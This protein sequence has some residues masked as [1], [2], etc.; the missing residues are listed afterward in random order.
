[1]I[2]ERDPSLRSWGFNFTTLFTISPNVDNLLTNPYEVVK[3][4]VLILV[5]MNALYLLV[6]L[7]ELRNTGCF[8]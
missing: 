4:S 1:M 3:V 8:R 6:F 5:V 7:N 2:P